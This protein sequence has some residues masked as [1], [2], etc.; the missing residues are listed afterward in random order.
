MSARIVRVPP[1]LSNFKIETKIM[2]RYIT[3]LVLKTAFSAPAIRGAW[4]LQFCARNGRQNP[5]ANRQ[6]RSKNTIWYPEC[7][8]GRNCIVG[9]LI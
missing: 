8:L 3:G 2:G 6:L 7:G 1:S 4:G 9:L 5:S